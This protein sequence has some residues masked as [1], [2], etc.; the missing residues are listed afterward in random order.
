MKYFQKNPDLGVVSL[1]G[2]GPIKENEVLVGD[3]FEQYAPQLLVEVPA[4]RA[5]VP[6][7]SRASQSGPVLL[8]EPAPVGP[9]TEARQFSE[10]APTAAPIKRG[11]GR[12][13]KNP[14]PL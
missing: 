12:P 7:E 13:R 3:H 4:H 11:R 10:E 8:T 1:P 6:L 14:L 5:G 2:V 9:H